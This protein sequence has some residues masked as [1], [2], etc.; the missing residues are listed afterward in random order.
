M[1]TV[2]T[3]IATVALAALC[4]GCANDKPNGQD[5]AAAKDSVGF[6]LEIDGVRVYRF[7]D[8]GLYHYFAVPRNGT[9]AMAF[10]GWTESCGKGCTRQVNEEVAFTG[11]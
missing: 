8:Q 2:T 11:R 5:V 9:Y 3:V 10:E 4:T 6:L 1:R 7:G